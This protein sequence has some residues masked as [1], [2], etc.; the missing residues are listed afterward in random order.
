MSGPW[1]C[2]PKALGSARW[3]FIF[4]C[5]RPLSHSW[6]DPQLYWGSRDLALSSLP[7]SFPGHLLMS[8]R[9]VS[10]PH[11]PSSILLPLLSPLFFVPLFLSLTPIPSIFTPYPSLSS[12]GFYFPL[13]P[14]SFHPLMHC[15]FLGTHLT[16]FVFSQTLQGPSS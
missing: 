8:L 10:P 3:G 16:R 9:P 5:N 4:W 2:Q 1:V 12:R 15:L 11:S 14:L 7:P 13:F 6:F